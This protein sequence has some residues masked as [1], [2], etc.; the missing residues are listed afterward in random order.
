MVLG[1]VETAIGDLALLM[2][3]ED[4]MA[5][6]MLDEDHMDG[7]L[8]VGTMEELGVVRILCRDGA[9]LPACLTHGL[10]RPRR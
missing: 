10:K 6:R 9:R 2:L 8:R 3:D 1:Q 5:L 4:H 7:D